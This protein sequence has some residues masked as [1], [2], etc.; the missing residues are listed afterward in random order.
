MEELRIGMVGAGWVTQYHLPA[1]HK[2]AGRARVVAIADPSGAVREARQVGFDIADAFASCEDM[3]DTAT[4]DA[5][6]VCT[7]R[8]AHASTVAAAAARGLPVLCQKPLAPT[9]TEAQALVAAIGPA[10]RLMVH[11]NWRFRPVYRQLKTWLDAGVADRLRAVRLDYQSS[12]M[13]PVADGSRP[14]LTRQP[15]LRKLP[16]ML[17]SEIL[18][19]HLD[20]FRYL[21][22]ELEV[23]SAHLERT[24]D[25]IIGEDVAIITL[26]SIG[27]NFPV[28]IVGN[29]AVH[30]APP[31]PTDRMTLYGTTA[32]VTV[33]GAALAVRGPKGNEDLHFGDGA[34]YQGGYDGA[35]RHF[36]DCLEMGAPFETRPEDN[37]KTLALVEA[38]YEKAGAV[39]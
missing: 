6:D 34:N 36:V 4:L 10:A 32:T 37:L 20:A 1:W 14:A 19:H 31:L 33:D 3:L 13:I 5:V 35:I 18:I 25:E 22:G 11:D 30:G 16:R 39:R 23:V 38:I 15:F 9:L 17:V 21:L 7:P 2:L 28:Q 12:G 27:D 8:E 26:A 29:L 24:N